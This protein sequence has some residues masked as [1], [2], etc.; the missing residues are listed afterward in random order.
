MFET[1]Y[2]RAFVLISLY[3]IVI[4]QTQ[5][6]SC[7]YQKYAVNGCED[8]LGADCDTTTSTCRCKPSNWVVIDNRFCFPAQCPRGEYYDH[9]L[10]RCEPQR[11][12]TL[13]SEENYCKHN[14]HCRGINQQIFRVQS[15]G[16]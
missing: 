10:G 5:L 2:L 13:N 12:A 14:F 9:N 16:F 4:S 7:D 11:K 3:S 6:G 1:I 15:I 8:E